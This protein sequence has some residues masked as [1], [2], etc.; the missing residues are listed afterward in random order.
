MSL[1]LQ[2]LQLQLQSVAAAVQQPL[3]LQFF[4]K[5]CKGPTLWRGKG[6]NAGSI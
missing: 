3:Q 6:K 1:N 2:R 4:G 5:W